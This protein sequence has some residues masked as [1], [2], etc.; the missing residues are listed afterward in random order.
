MPTDKYETWNFRTI[1]GQGTVVDVSYQLTSPKLF[2]PFLY[3][4]L[5]APV[6]FAGLI[7]PVVQVSNLISQMVAAPLLVGPLLRKWYMILAIVATSAALVIIGI[8]SY[9]AAS[10]WLALQFLLAAAIMG[11]S[12]GVSTLAYQDLIGRILPRNRRS[13]LL[14]TQAALAAVFTILI[15]VSSQRIGEHPNS[16]GEHLELLW[17]G[18][19]LTLFA[20]VI[21]I[22]IRE[23]PPQT[24][25]ATGRRGPNGTD[26]KGGLVSDY[27]AQLGAA[28]KLDWFRRFLVARTL[29]LSIE[30]AMPFYALHAAA[31]HGDHKGSL[32]TFV[33]GSSIGIIA[34]GMIWQRVARISTPAVMALASLVACAAGVLSISTYLLPELRIVWLHGGVFLLIAM[35]NEGT[36][37][38]RK[39]YIVDFTSDEDRPYYIALSN[40]FVGVF[41]AIVSFAFGV[42]AHLQHVV[43]PIWLIVGINLVACLYS[44]QLSSK[45]TPA[46]A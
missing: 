5:G 36:R 43:W 30:M 29:F 26:A 31:Y 15:A 25:N 28:L 45:R 2:L 13:S 16:I 44:R 42:L 24:A 20:A 8:A 3:M 23:T 27:L 7:L 19:A 17:A 40:V 33:I 46:P 21:T 11:T 32:S 38:A 12:Q 1:L 37:N 35:A 14:F 39:L 22:L 34:G 18:V 4:A 41:G 6:L 10:E 9:S